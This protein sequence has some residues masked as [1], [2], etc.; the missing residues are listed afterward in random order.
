MSTSQ[1]RPRRRL[2]DYDGCRA[3]DVFSQ[4]AGLSER[5]LMGAA[6]L[7]SFYRLSQSDFRE[8]LLGGRL[9]A[10]CGP[11]NNGGDAL[12][13]VFML[14][15]AF[16]YQAT[17]V[18]V[19]Q[20]APAKT[21]TARYY[22]QELLGLGVEMRTVAE[23]LALELQA[24]DLLVE[25]LLG[26]GQKSP[27]RE[28]TLGILKKIQQA[29]QAPR[30]PALVALD[31]PAG[32]V[33][34]TLVHFSPP[35]DPSG[36]FA[37]PDEIHAYGA[38]KLALRLQP[39]LAAFSNIVVLPMGFHPGFEADAARIELFEAAPER[40]FFLKRATG[41]KYAAGHGLL[42][43]G[44]QGMEGA[45]LLA[46]RSF[47]AAGG[48]ILHVLVPEEKSR[49]FL[50]ASHPEIMFHSFDRFPEH[51]RPAAVAM[52]PGLA[53]GDLKHC[54]SRL[55]N[56]LSAC[57]SEERGP[58]VILDAGALGL[59]FDAGFP[60]MLRPQT[61]C[62]PHTGEWKKMGGPP[63]TY[64]EGLFA[65]LNWNRE[66]TGCFTLV[67]D[68]VSVLLNPSGVAGATQAWVHSKP[69]ASLATAGSGD[70]LTG[71]LLAA[72]ARRPE[73]VLPEAVGAALAL[74]RAAGARMHPTAGEFPD[75]IRGVLSGEI[76]F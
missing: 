11:G 8:R 64:T 16:E 59:V 61:I 13:L 73:R 46:A 25:A 20:T 21:A 30:P 38:D 71:V 65:A 41:H 75:L 34:N 31:T 17:T 48:G 72:L 32:L 69:L 62:T 1:T 44:S 24:S 49:E 35:G 28:P 29:R 42:V 56:W 33:E 47:F 37:A 5:Q 14:L 45:I 67:K 58:F 2:F 12:A 15:G 54:G 19:F 52:G 6:A 36:D 76:S 23:F 68:C 9:V 7:A 60:D 70:S 63:A 10:L 53:A 66:R 39:D 26:T 3:L 27:P 74:Q 22:E 4:Q 50:T 55:A 40:S 43:G 57:A 18:L 51:L